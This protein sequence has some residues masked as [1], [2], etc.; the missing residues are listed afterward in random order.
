MSC[1]PP[2]QDLSVLPRVSVLIPT[3]NGLDHLKRLLPA[4]R[5]QI[6]P[7]GVELCVTDSSSSDGTAEF[8]KAESESGAWTAGDLRGISVR[9][10]ERERFHH[11][12][13][14]NQLAE[15]A[16]GEFLVFLSQDALPQGGDFLATLLQPF[17]DEKVAG[18][19][20]RVLP[21]PS[22]DPL[23][24]RTVLGDAQANAV[25]HERSLG[26]ARSFDALS[27]AERLDVLRFNNVSSAIRARVFGELPF[28]D[29]DFGEDFAW[30]GSALR[31]G[32]K[33]VFMP[34]AVVLHSH[35]YGARS[36]FERYRQDARF[37]SAS[38]GHRLRPSL[39]SAL[40]G[41]VYEV[42]AD[43]LFILRGGGAPWHL[44][45]SP[46]LRTGQI[47]GQWVGSRSGDSAPARDPENPPGSPSGTG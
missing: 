26:D 16:H 36:A 7:G 24:R 20:A 37:H 18:V 17:E 27:G 46:G 29:V 28:P 42:G 12:R 32:W 34:E 11:G 39:L 4:L 38:H 9:T 3:W 23:T 5:S 6:L 35:R 19:T 14:R 15:S 21:D 43:A 44:L 2:D 10:I 47:L 45:R 22:H 25:G 33:T 41:I 30:A 8:L 1:P 40:R 13:T 31:A